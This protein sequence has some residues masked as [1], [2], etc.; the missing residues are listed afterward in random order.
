M[1]CLYMPAAYA[2]ETKLAAAG[3]LPRETHPVFRVKF[4]FIDHMRSSQTL[5]RLPQYLH[6]TFG[7]A[8][9]QAA[10][11]AEACPERIAAAR[12][13]LDKAQTEEGRERLAAR[14]FP[15]D[16]RRR[17]EMATRRAELGRNA[18][19]RSQAG[20]LWQEIKTLDQSLLKRQI[21]WTVRQLRVRDLEFADS[22]GAL[23]PWSIAL[24]G[25]P[26]YQ[27]LLAATKIYAEN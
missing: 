17:Q 5:I 18:E 23:L 20:A 1:G 7:A 2:F 6:E 9:M 3:L 14:L 4:N 8:E 16:V 10:E 13:D 27:Q 25:E 11:F 22:R 24:G 26:F 21:D 19:T 15:D 12:R